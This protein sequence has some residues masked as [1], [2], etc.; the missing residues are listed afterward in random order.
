MKATIAL[1]PGDGVGQEVIDAMARRGVDDS[2]S[3]FQRHVVGEHGNRVTVVEWVAK[4]QAVQLSA[5]KPGDGWRELAE[6]PGDTGRG[7]P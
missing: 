3:L 6:D 4:T 7:E 1:L 5:L 2:G